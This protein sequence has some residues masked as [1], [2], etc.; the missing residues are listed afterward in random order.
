LSISFKQVSH[1]YIGNR[2]NLVYSYD[3]VTGRTPPTNPNPFHHITLV[4]FVSL[5]GYN[6]N[7]EKRR[8]PY[9]D[10][11]KTDETSFGGFVTMQ[12]GTFR[13]CQQL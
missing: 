2:G 5:V 8:T 6:W 3:T 4:G 13:K 9:S 12:L 11:A 10:N 7:S 1:E